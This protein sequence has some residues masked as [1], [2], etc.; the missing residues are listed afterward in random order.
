MLR[1]LFFE[2]PEDETTWFI[3]DQYLFGSHLLVAPLFEAHSNSRKV[4]LPHGEWIDYQSGERFGGGQWLEIPAGKIPVVLL[5]KA[6]S[7]LATSKVVQSTDQIDWNDLSYHVYPTQSHS[8]EG[9][10]IDIRTGALCTLSY[11]NDELYLN[12]DSVA[13]AQVTL[14]R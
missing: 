12:G 7:I 1:T 9:H 4:Y 5:V 3:E 2:F 8:A 6:G 13:A 10:L 14:Y 11:Q